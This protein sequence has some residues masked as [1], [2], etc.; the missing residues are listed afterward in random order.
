MFRIGQGYDCHR[1]D[2][3][4]PLVLAGVQIPG[5]AGL[6]GHSDADCCLHAVTDAILGA[7]AAG[8]IGE[9]FPDSDPRWAGADSR[10]MLRFAVDLARREGFAVGNCDVTIL[11]ERPKL[12][13]HK[14]RMAE[15]LAEL[16]DVPSGRASVKAKTNER[17]GW[18]GRGEGLATLAV[19][20]LVAAG[21]EERT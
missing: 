21:P 19:V 18:L 9:H 13:Q 8:D 6:A 15:S 4:R 7:L 12:S 10:R 1:F 2:E 11:A 14:P 20:L 17:M 5:A 16:L 3:S